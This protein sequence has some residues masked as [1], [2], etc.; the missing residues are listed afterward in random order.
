MKP[1]PS[2]GVSGLTVVIPAYNEADAIGTTLATLQ[3]TLSG[4]KTAHEIIVVD[5]GSSDETAETARDAG[6]KVI[7]HPV[8]SGYGRSLLTGIEA[9]KH[10]TIAI[11]DADGTYPIERLP[12]LLSLFEKG[13][14]MVV[15]ARQGRYYD[16]SWGK[17]SLRFIFRRLAEFT[18]G[19]KIPDI[20]SGFRI[21]DR[22]PVLAWRSS[23]STGFS[24]TTTVTLIFMLNGLMV[25]YLPVAYHKRVGQSKVRLFR[26]SMRS[27]QIIT[28]A[29]A[30]FNPL[31]LYLL[32]GLVNLAGNGALIGAVYARTL[33]GWPVVL[34]T[35]GWNTLCLLA[36]GSI[37]ALGILRQP[38]QKRE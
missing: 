11:V 33:E 2:S 32:L 7:Q 21:F 23:V 36:G 3:K 18:C 17:K 31:K 9:A 22:G 38:P 15:A 14:D 27:L 34:A 30:Q 13:F 26:D 8:N 4:L 29:I 12:D 35:C 10:E 28:T 37:L 20:N 19:R 24:F 6:A 16:T 5:D 25:G 1:A